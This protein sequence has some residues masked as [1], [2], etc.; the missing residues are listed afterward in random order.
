MA[1][2]NFSSAVLFLLLA[3]VINNLKLSLCQELIRYALF[4]SGPVGGF[5]TSGV[6]PA[7]E[8]AEELINADIS[9]LPGY[10]LTHTPVVDTMC[11][12]TV[13]LNEYFDAISPPHPTVLGLLGCGCSVASTPVAEIIHHNSISQVSYASSSIELSDRSRFLNFF[14]TYPS[15]ADFAPAVVSLIQEYGWRR[16]AFITQD[17]SLFTEVLVNL[18]GPLNSLGIGIVNK[19]V[20]STVYNNGFSTSDA[21]LIFEKDGHRVFFINAFSNLG[22]KIMCEAYI[23]GFIYPNYAWLTYGWYQDRWWTE[24]VNP[25]PTN[26]T[27]D[28]LAE[29]LH[30]S[31]ALQ[32]RPELNDSKTITESQLKP[33]EFDSLYKRRLAINTQDNYTYTFFATVAYDAL[34]TFALALNR[35]NEMIGGLIREEILNMTQCGGTDEETG[36]KWEVVSLE[37]FTYSNQLM[38]CIIRWNLERTDFVGVSGQVTFDD[39]GSRVFDDVMF[40]QYRLSAN[41]SSLTRVLFA[42]SHSI[43]KSSAEFI[44]I[45]G[46]NNN[47]V[48]PQGIPPDGIPIPQILTYHLALVIPYYILAAVGLVFCTVCLIFNFTQRKKKIVKITSPNINYIII[49]GAYMMYS[50]IYFRILPSKDFT[51]NVVRCFIDYLASITGY[52]LAYAAILVKMGRVYYIFHNPSLTKKTLKDWK[53]FLIAISISSVGVILAVLQ[54]AVPQLQPIPHVSN[55][56]E[57]T[58]QI[59]NELGVMIEQQVYVCFSFGQNTFATIWIVLIVVY[60]ALLQIVGLILAFQTRK[61]KIKQL[62][63]SKY[64]AG[65]IYASAISLV[66]NAIAIAIDGSLLNTVETLFSG[67]LLAATTV[68]LALAFIPT[69]VSLYRDSTGK[70]IMGE[71]RNSVTGNKMSGL[72]DVER[73]TVESKQTQMELRIQEL[74]KVVRSYESNSC[75]SQKEVNSSTVTSNRSGENFQP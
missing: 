65:M 24:E 35:T 48:F 44:Y 34:W 62:H 13:S 40:F 20:S 71:R 59:F 69:M 39:T 26:C 43:N 67:S 3:V 47:S 53:L 60:T 73:R 25:E 36:V 38:G 61:V 49:V 4:T 51:L 14:H 33:T 7:I 18:R 11:D 45:N 74:E 10:N 17:E 55:S 19:I 21:D 52:N 37:N 8:L 16:I 70:F 29:A 50:S 56:S 57:S 31:I 6:V 42:S 5:H 58:Q 30:R 72:S 46:E 28:Q 23:R 22:R 66:I 64:I 27:D 54:V 2:F 41:N 1:V 9:I 75:V 32:L 15:D 68:F 63:D 12:R